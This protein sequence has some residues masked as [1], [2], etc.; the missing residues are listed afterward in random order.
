MYRT[1]F[2]FSASISISYFCI[3]QVYIFVNLRLTI[4][5]SNISV[6]WVYNVKLLTLQDRSCLLSLSC[7]LN[8]ICHIICIYLIEGPKCCPDSLLLY[9]SWYP[10]GPLCITQIAHVFAFVSRSRCENL[11]LPMYYKSKFI[12]K[13]FFCQD[14]SLIWST[15]RDH[16]RKD[17]RLPPTAVNRLIL[18]A[19]VV[20][21]SKTHNLILCHG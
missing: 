16:G 8:W 21:L 12:C 13:N 15:R 1:C 14:V 18:K 3:I 19:F 20:K 4:L 7:E 10:L 5:S 17:L 2:Y 11:V 6:L 9:F